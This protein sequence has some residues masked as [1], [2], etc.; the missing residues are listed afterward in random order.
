MLQSLA[1]HDPDVDG[2]YR[3]TQ[4]RLPFNF[5]KPAA[6]QRPALQLETL[7]IPQSSDAWSPA[8][9]TRAAPG[10]HQQAAA[11]Q[12]AAQQAAERLQRD[13]GRLLEADPAS[14]TGVAR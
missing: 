4:R 6:R 14:P 12:A 1:D 8:A 10:R 9:V 3:L 2:I 5:P 7:G 11:Q 13:A